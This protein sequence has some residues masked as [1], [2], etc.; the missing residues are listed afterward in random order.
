[1]NKA[2][3]FIFLEIFLLTIFM[4]IF[5]LCIHSSFPYKLISL[6]GLVFLCFIIAFRLLKNNHKSVPFLIT[7]FGIK[8]F[9]GK[10][11]VYTI[12]C[13]MGGLILGMALRAWKKAPLIPGTVTFFAIGIAPLI[14]MS[15]ELL[16][17]GYIQNRLYEI[18]G[19]PAVILAALSHTIYKCSLMVLP[20]LFNGAK[21][22]YFALWTFTG[23][24]LFGILSK[25]SNTVYPALA[26]H[27]VFDI[28]VYGASETAPWW[29]W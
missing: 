14:G 17:R 12:L 15:E 9:T 24:L 29:G 1:M 4:G 16:F 7:F 26:G 18:N 28:V 8:P 6:S 27:A 11:L 25:K 19:L 23:G 22:P 5:G 13:L 10:A 3:S 20:P 2:G 21:I